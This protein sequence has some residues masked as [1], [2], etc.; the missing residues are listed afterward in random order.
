MVKTKYIF[1]AL[2]ILLLLSISWRPY[3]Q[4]LRGLFEGFFAKEIIY[5]YVPTL[6]DTVYRKI[7]VGEFESNQYHI[8]RDDS[9]QYVSDKIHNHMYRYHIKW[10]HENEYYL[11]DS[12]RSVLIR[13]KV[14]N[15]TDSSFTLIFSYFGNISE[16]HK[17]KI[18]ST[19]NELQPKSR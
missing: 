1:F 10:I 6:Q 8:V 15:L 9:I 14:N 16:R 2:F 19:K 5:D 7:R 4:Y 12:S 13:N 17:F 18:I 11:I 3:R